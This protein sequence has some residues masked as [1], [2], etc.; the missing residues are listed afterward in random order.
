MTDCPQ[1]YYNSL[2]DFDFT[3]QTDMPEQR[4]QVS[5]TWNFLFEILSMFCCL[6]LSLPQIA[7]EFGFGYLGIEDS[8]PFVIEISFR[9]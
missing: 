4:S 8:I 7:H 9:H 6:L 3:H 2:T 5:P 1:Q